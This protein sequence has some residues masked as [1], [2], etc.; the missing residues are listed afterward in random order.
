MMA[1]APL[2]LGLLLALGADA[3]KPP[4]DATDPALEDVLK[5]LAHSCEKVRDLR[6]QFTQEKILTIFEEK[7]KTSGRLFYKRPQLIVWWQE[8]PEEMIIWI[9]GTEMLEYEKRINQVRKYL[10]SEQDRDMWF[11]SVRFD[12]KTLETRFSLRLK[13][14]TS[15]GKDKLFVIELVPNSEDLAA[16]IE[17]V[18]VTVS[19]KNWLVERVSIYETN[20]DVLNIRF[21][22]IRINAGI[23]EARDLPKLPADAQ[24]IDL[25]G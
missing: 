7:E 17:R 10:L 21:R 18:E 4:A 14:T 9:H 19:S 23:D 1:L 2:L 25:S 12:R 13:E 11:L 22:N 16:D 3:C 24:V 15:S 8:K 20:R 6:A 5:N